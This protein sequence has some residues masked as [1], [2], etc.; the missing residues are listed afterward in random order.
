MRFISTRSANSAQLAP[1]PPHARPVEGSLRIKLLAPTPD[2]HEVRCP[3]HEAG[4]AHRSS[5]ELCKQVRESR[6]RAD[7]G[8]VPP[9]V[10]TEPAVEN[11]EA[12]QILDLQPTGETA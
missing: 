2:Q 8:R 7:C 9:L 1:I 12:A 4:I 6:I 10:G 3:R 5:F 11:V